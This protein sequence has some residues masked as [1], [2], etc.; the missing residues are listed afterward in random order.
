MMAKLTILEKR[1]FH[2]QV[3]NSWLPSC[4]HVFTRWME[5]SICPLSSEINSGS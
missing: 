5:C 2:L 3:V 4:D 1:W